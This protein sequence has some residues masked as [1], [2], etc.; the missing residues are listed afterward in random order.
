M[1]P[2]TG[3]GRRGYSGLPWSE[4]P[5]SGYLCYPGGGQNLYAIPQDFSKSIDS[6]DPQIGLKSGFD[7]VVFQRRQSKSYFDTMVSF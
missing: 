6:R 7:F 2:V 3:I 4:S 1:L 5:S